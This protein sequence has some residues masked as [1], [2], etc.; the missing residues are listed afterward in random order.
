MADLLAAGTL[1]EIGS[2]TGQ[3]AVHIAERM[4]YITWQCSD[5]P[6]NLPG[7]QQ[8]LDDAK[9]PNLPPPM[10]YDVN[11]PWPFPLTVRSVWDRSGP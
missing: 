11:S 4:G 3:H 1:V 10:E 9:L 8:W 6:E 7:I 5:R 2:G